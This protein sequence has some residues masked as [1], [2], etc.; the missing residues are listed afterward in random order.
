MLPATVE[1]RTN[2]GGPLAG[3]LEQVGAGDVGQ[4]L[5]RLEEAVHAEAPGVDHPLGDP[6]VVEVEDLLA[7]V[8]VLEQRRAA[9]AHAQRVLVVGDRHPLLGR[10]RLTGSRRLVGLAADADFG[11]RRLAFT[12]E[13]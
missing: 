1:K 13:W 2:T 12:G 9:L 4:R 10:Q 6:L 8:E 3:T 7:E 5:V 11:C